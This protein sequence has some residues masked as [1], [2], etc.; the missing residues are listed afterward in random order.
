MYDLIEN[1]F[2]FEFNAESIKIDDVAINLEQ[3]EI[4]WRLK[5]GT[6]PIGNNLSIQEYIKYTTKAIQDD[7]TLEVIKSLVGKFD[8][9]IPLFA[10]R[11]RL[12]HLTR[13]EQD[14][15]INSLS[16]NDII[17]LS[18]LNEPWSYTEE[19]RSAG[20]PTPISGDLFFAILN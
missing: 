6:M 4:T 16:K 17:E 15:A 19:Q 5:G 11:N 3:V 13:F 10:I 14:E 20:I 12:T 18:K 1:K 7:E 8:N 9:Y 2:P